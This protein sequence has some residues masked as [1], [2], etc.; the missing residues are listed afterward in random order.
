VQQAVVVPVPDEIKQQLPFAFVVRAAS[1][2]GALVTES[3]IKQ[4][5]LQ[6]GPAYQHPR[7]IEFI[8][9]MP[10]AGTNKIDREALKQ[11]ARDLAAVK[12]R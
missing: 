2:G 4:W 9:A 1:E 3:D 7:W 12:P 6:H 10:L 5:T 11:R 8:T